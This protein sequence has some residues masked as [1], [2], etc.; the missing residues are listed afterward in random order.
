VICDAN[1]VAAAGW[2]IENLKPDVFVLDDGFQH[3]R[4][5]R[6][7][8]IL[9]ID[10][11]NPWGNGHLLPA[12]ILREPRASLQRADCILITRSDQSDRVAELHSEIEAIRDDVPVF[13]SKM[14]LTNLRS[15]GHERNAKPRSPL[16]AFCGIANPESFFTMLRDTG[17]DLAD[18]RTFRDHHN[19]T[20]H[21]IDRLLAN[22]RRHG[23][24]ALVTTAKDAVKV[25]SMNFD[26]PCYV[27][28]I[29]IEINPEDQFRQ[30][31]MNS[32]KV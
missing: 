16:T 15:L 17:Y 4:I 8:N 29:E 28:E 32:I 2:A 5:A 30:L 12:G 13:L 1:R 25:R 11:T 14:T 24:Q 19:Y 18:V 26:L 23:A 20:Q 31:I 27:A 9:A 3:Q 10:A 21:E 22:A 6:N 7:L